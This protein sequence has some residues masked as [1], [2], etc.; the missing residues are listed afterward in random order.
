MARINEEMNLLRW[1]EEALGGF[2]DMELSVGNVNSW[3]ESFLEAAFTLQQEE[4]TRE[5]GGESME[6]DINEEE[7][8]S[9][10]VSTWRC[11]SSVLEQ[12]VRQSCRP[13]GLTR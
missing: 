4:K 1:V 11:F 6:E 3:V 7:E 12:A 9:C 5:E 13:V 10:M 2:H 8:R